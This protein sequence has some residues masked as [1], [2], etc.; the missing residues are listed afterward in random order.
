MKK[1]LSETGAIT[2]PDFAFSGAVSPIGI[3]VVYPSIVHSDESTVD[4]AERAINH[5]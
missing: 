2:L 1:I 4:F 5:S 3:V